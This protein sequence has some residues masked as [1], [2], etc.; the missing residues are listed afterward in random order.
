MFQEKGLLTILIWQKL[1]AIFTMCLLRRV[2]C[3]RLLDSG[4]HWAYI[5]VKDVLSRRSQT[6]IELQ[7]EF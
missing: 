7:I 2:G 1:L 3:N 6:Q 5:Q 4:L